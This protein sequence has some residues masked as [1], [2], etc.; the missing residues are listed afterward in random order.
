M[1]PT[2][3]ELNDA[4]LKITMA[5]QA[6]YPELSK[7]LSEMPITIPSNPN[8]DIKVKNLSDYYESLQQLVSKYAETHS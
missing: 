7:Y 5:I 2:E 4:I 1:M 6:D 3:K 8:P